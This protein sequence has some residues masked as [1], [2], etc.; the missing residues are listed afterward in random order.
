MKHTS[1][2][3]RSEELVW[4]WKETHHD[5]VKAAEDGTNNSLERY[6]ETMEKW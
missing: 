2:H 6:A 3:R 5:S 1:S 4:A